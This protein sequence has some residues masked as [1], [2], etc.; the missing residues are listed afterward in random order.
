[1]TQVPLKF[2]DRAVFKPGE[3]IFRE[4]DAGDRAYVITQGSVEI[5]KQGGE[6]KIVLEVIGHQAIFGEMALIDD[7]PRSATAVAMETT[8]CVVLHYK[9]LRRKLER[10]DP[11]L[12]ALLRI[13][14][15][16]VR[17]TN[18]MLANRPS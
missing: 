17:S 2:L 1:M 15:R 10:S 3:V 4:G 16:N 7:E 12:R 18:R 14:V 5:S 8:Q 9:D 6:H 11:F 13:M